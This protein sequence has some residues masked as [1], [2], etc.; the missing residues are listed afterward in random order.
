MTHSTRLKANA[1]TL[2]Y[3]VATIV[4]D[5]D[6]TIPDRS[7]TVIVG[8]NGSGKS[9][10]LKALGRLLAPR[11]G[12]VILDGQALGAY[13]S[14]EIARRIGILPQSASAPAGIT[15]GDLVA[16]GRY[17][18]QSFLRQW[19][20]AD[21]RAVDAA[22]AAAGVADLA[23]R[24]V[25][26]LSGGQRQR[27]W[28]A[29][30]LAQQTPILLLDEPTTYLDMAHQLELL[31]LLADLNETAGRTI[32]AV[33]H[34]LNQACRYASHIVALKAGRV[35]AEG[36]PA[37]IVTEALL[38]TVFGLSCMIIDD[39]ITGTPHVVPRGRLGAGRRGEV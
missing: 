25:E 18:H 15:V 28:I 26:T 13:P 36:Q 24:R 3:G 16:R 2:G 30:V 8:A 17:P 9:T 38:D 21:E 39:P 22:L 23:S 11:T 5:L 29:M 10:L 6:I 37:D 14:I 20:R 32:V 31:D 19:S 12:M 1:L 35:V 4:H 27:A 33:L 7:F 34:D